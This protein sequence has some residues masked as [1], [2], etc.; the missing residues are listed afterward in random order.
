MKK[1]RAISITP[2]SLYVTVSIPIG[3]N[4]L[5]ISLPDGSQVYMDGGSSLTYCLQSSGG[6]AGQRIAAL[7]GQA[8]FK[9]AH[10]SLLFVLETS[11]AEMLVYGT[12][13]L[14]RDFH[15]EDTSAIYQYTDRMEVSNGRGRRTLYPFQ[16]AMIDP[17]FASIRVVATGDSLPNPVFRRQDFDFTHQ[18]LRGALNEL[19]KWYGIRSVHVDPALGADTVRPLSLGLI[20]KDLSLDNLIEK[21]QTDK[22]HFTANE[23]VISATK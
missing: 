4:T 21:L 3:V 18:T 6:I 12:S 8:S 7:D 16:R 1:I 23:D 13:F 17:S 11:R 20:S 5:Q 15:K 10:D 19:A 2:G 22:M 14:V 9:I